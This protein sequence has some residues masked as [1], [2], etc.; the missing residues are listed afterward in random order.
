MATE[1]LKFR[2]L[3]SVT[4][5]GAIESFR[6]QVAGIGRDAGSVRNSVGSLTNG[7]K[8]LAGAYVVNE[9]VQFGRSLIQTADSLDELSEKTGVAVSELAALSGA[10]QIEGI[11]IDALGGL[12][13]KLSIASVEAANGNRQLAST[14]KAIGVNVRDSGGG[15]KSAGELTRE[16]ADRFKNLKDGPEKAAIAI[17]LFG[18]S[19]SDIIPLL[20]KGSEE[21][22]KFSLRIGDDF[23]A[24]AGQF[25]DSIALIGIQLKNNLSE[26]IEAALPALQDILNVFLEAPAAAEDT[27]S[28]FEAIGE[29]IRVTAAVV[30]VFVEAFKQGLDTVIVLARTVGGAVANVFEQIG[31]AISTRAQQIKS[32][33]SLNFDEAS[34]LEDAFNARSI[35]RA[36][37]AASERERLFSQLADRTEKRVDRTFAITDRLS[38]N[39]FLFGEGTTDEIRQRQRASTAPAPR[40]Q[41]GGSVDSGSFGNSDTERDR[42]KEFIDQQKLETEQRRLAL[43]DINLTRLELLKVTEARKIEADAIRQGKALNEEQRLA[44]QEATVEII[45]QREALIELERAQSRSFGAGARE[46]LRDY[47]E[48]ATNTAAQVKQVFGTAFKGAEDALTS[49]VQTG[50][51]DFKSLANS[52]IEDLIR[53]QIRRALAGAVSAASTAFAGFGATGFANGGIMTGEGQVPLQKYARGGVANSPQL[54]LFGEGSMPEA[55][56]PLPDGRRI[57]VAMEGQGGGSGPVNVTVVVNAQTGAQETE[58]STGDARK[59]AQLVGNLVKNEIVNQKRP[60]GLLTA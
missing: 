39:S 12:L 24:R 53:I 32:L 51:L 50:K 44:L 6:K 43:G 13:R 56:V 10:A 23:A 58:G 2:V 1:D 16:L 18:K 9:A 40:V 45:A 57:P 21:I 4:G 15:I 11:S 17:K 3:A 28:T 5:Q 42:I 33:T 59:L 31:D 46:F 27:V 37:A 7:L 30:N 55:Y 26:G 48:E 38:Q 20:N 60:G 52:I 25:N 41:G 36:R 35:E 29:A 8:A 47:V 19:G 14:F 34:R 22:D 54:A 49:F